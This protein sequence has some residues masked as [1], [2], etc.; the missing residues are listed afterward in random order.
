MN[1]PAFEAAP[2]LFVIVIVGMIGVF[3]PYVS[4]LVFF[5]GRRY[6]KAVRWKGM[7]AVGK[8]SIH[9]CR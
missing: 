3:A 8:A 9:S 7:D 5:L 2:S 4:N 6:G 1:E